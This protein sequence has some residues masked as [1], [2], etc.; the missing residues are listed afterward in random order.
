MTSRETTAE[1]YGLKDPKYRM[2]EPESSDSWCA[3]RR[4]FDALAAS[5]LFAIRRASSWHIGALKPDEPLTIEYSPVDPA[6]FD[7][8][9]PAET[10]E[11]LVWP[12]SV[13]LNL[14]ALAPDD[15]CSSVDVPVWIPAL[16]R[17]VARRYDLSVLDIDKD[18]QGNACWITARIH[19][20]RSA[21][22][23]A[24]LE[25]VDAIG[26]ALAAA[27]QEP[28]LDEL[29][30]LFQ[31]GLVEGFIG[32]R[33]SH[34]F[35]AKRA[36]YNLNDV[37]CRREW[38]KDV[39]AMANSGGGLLVVGYGTRRIDDVDTVHA[40][41]PC[42][43]AL[44]EPQRYRRALRGVLYP[45][46]SGLEF[47]YRRVTADRGVLAVRIAPQPAASLPI[48]VVGMPGRTRGRVEGNYVG[49]FQRHSDGNV[50]ATG[51]TIHQALNR[52]YSS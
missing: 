28:S 8:N 5:D 3:P 52:I 51:A 26:R 19:L 7:D 50:P 4:A 27:P 17:R 33:E 10:S 18:A 13:Q 39:S 35:D 14:I 16:I 23:S 30:N 9:S 45:A 43:A 6:D 22:L 49:L 48:L 42:P 12:R 2:F 38:A 1:E 40:L 24:V 34:S 15:V 31:D 46:P 47:A 21:Q 41:R 32:V 44:I 36:P 25:F 29:W 11:F 37:V 20:R